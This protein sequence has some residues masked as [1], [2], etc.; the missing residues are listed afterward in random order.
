[1]IAEEVVEAAVV[2]EAIEEAAAEA[3]AEEIVEAAAVVEAVEA[4]EERFPR[5]Q[6]GPKQKKKRLPRSLRPQKTRPTA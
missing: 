6:S 4:A 1:M 3:V 5:P 2:E